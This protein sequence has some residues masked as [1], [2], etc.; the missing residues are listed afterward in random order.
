MAGYDKI[1]NGATIQATPFK[2]HV[3]DAKLK[4][5]L[6]LIRISPIG[7]ATYANT[8]KTQPPNGMSPPERSSGIP[9]DWLVNAKDQ[10][11]NAFD[12]RKHE[13]HINSFPHFTAPVKSDDG[14]E[15]T[16]HFMALF[17][18]RP[19]AVPIAFY[20]GWPGSF[21]EFTQIFQLLKDRYT[22]QDLPYHV[23]APSLPNYAFSSGPPLDREL[24]TSDAA[25]LLHNS[26]SGVASA[27]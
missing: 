16:V 15:V 26:C 19:D 1:P 9:R 24:E 14:Y 10:W 6:D 25:A 23:I 21:L 3:E 22:P 18:E 17:S 5:M 4:Q 7:P 11:L 27:P 2:V 13:D 20:H 8:S 12:W